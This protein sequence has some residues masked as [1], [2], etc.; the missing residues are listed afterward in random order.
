MNERGFEFVDTIIAE[1]VSVNGQ[2]SKREQVVESLKWLTDTVPDY[3]WNVDDLL[4]DGDRIAARLRDKGTPIKP[5]LGAEPTGA[6][7]EYIEFASYKGKDGLFTDMWY[8][9][10]TASILA[11]LNG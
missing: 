5:F 7:I 4:V 8:L 9:L 1:D 11:Q 6:T 10:D 2:Q 3:L